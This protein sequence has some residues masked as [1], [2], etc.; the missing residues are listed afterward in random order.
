MCHNFLNVIKGCEPYKPYPRP[1]YT[2]SY[3]PNFLHSS[4]ATSIS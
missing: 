1:S 2:K 3:A 4:F